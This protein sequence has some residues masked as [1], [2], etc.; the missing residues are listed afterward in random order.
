MEQPIKLTPINRSRSIN[1]HKIFN[2]ILIIIL[3]VLVVPAVISRISHQSSNNS[4][5]TT[6]SLNTD[7]DHNNLKFAKHSIT[8]VVE[9]VAPS[10]VSIVTASLDSSWFGRLERSGA[11]TGV[12]LS[13]DGYILTNKHV[14]NNANKVTIITSDGESYESAR[15]IFKDPFNDLAFIKVAE[16][17]N[18]KP[19]EIGDSKTVRVGQSVIAIGNSLGQYQNTVTQGIIS[20][21]S[22]NVMARDGQGVE[23][24]T[25]MLQTDAAINP[26]NSGGPLVNAGGQLI[27]INTAV[28]QGA[29]GLGFAIPIGAAK[30]LIKQLGQTEIQRAML[31]VRF[32]TLNP[33]LAKERKLAIKQGALIADEVV[34]DS[35]ADKAG[36]KK[37]DVIIAI[38]DAVVGQ[39]GGLNTL[40]SEYAVG[41][42]IQIKV[43]RD[44]RQLDFAVTLQALTD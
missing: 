9:R 41:E 30:G 19:I 7:K 34:K 6:I 37:N 31:G 12:I 8:E 40:I 14:I 20:G 3:I 4:S 39:A 35:A 23:A 2:L 1:S 21:T 42:T 28:T 29:N 32:V 17:K 43:I 38:G 18:F 22:R 5:K 24:L 11:G 25:D 36:L 27:G 10:V 33:A 15:V 13:A 26:G 16:P 44:N